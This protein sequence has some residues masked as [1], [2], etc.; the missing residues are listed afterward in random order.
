MLDNIKYYLSK[1]CFNFDSSTF[2]VFC[3]G[4]VFTFLGISRVNKKYISVPLFVNLYCT[5]VLAFH[6]ATT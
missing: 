1:T 2:K 4:H 5:Y 6:L 3:Q